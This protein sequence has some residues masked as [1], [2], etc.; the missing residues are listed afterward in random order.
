MQPTTTSEL[1]AA[2]AE[3]PTTDIQDFDNVLHLYWPRVFRFV[4]ASVRDRDAAETLTQDCFFRA[5]KGRM[6]FRGDSSIITWLM[7]IAVNLVRD[8]ARNRRLQFWR[9]VRSSGMEMADISDWIP[10]RGSSP[11]AKA[12]VKEQVKAIWAATE[13]LSDK[14]RTVF[15]LRF[16]EDMDLL[17]IAAATGM[18]EGAVKMH[19]FRAVHAIRDRIRRLQ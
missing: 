19:L 6:R 1:I 10:D 14:Q 2:S 7:R 13:Y 12:L 18:K 17:E 11:E 16:V 5:Y 4:L 15:L 3:S 8:F 9:R